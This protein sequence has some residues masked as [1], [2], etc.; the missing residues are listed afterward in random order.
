MVVGSGL[1]L[2]PILLPVSLSAQGPTTAAIQGTI[3]VDPQSEVALGRATVVLTNLPTGHRWL[4]STDDAGRYFIDGVPVGGP[5]AMDVEAAGFRPA[6]RSGLTLGLGQRYV[7]DFVLDPL[8]VLAD[9]IEVTL[10]RDPLSDVARTGPEHRVGLSTIAHL[11]VLNRDILSLALESP[12]AKSTVFGLSIAGHNSPYN[13]FQVD[14]GVN[15]NLYGR[16]SPVPGGLINLVSVPGGGGLRI[17]PID[18]VKEVQVL[19]SPFDVRQGS[20]VG[21]VINVVTESGTNILRGSGFVTLQ[22]DVLVGGESADFT[23]GQFGGTLGGAILPDRLHYFLAADLQAGSIPYGG[24]IIGPESIGGADSAG[25]GIR[26]ATATRFQSILRDTYGVDAGSFGPV[27]GQNPAQSLL[28]KLSWQS[29]TGNLLEISQTYVH[30][31]DQGLF[32]D[33][34]PYGNFDLTSADIRFGSTTSAT[35]VNWTAILGDR[36]SAE[37]IAA[38]LRIRDFCRGQEDS[39][40]FLSVFADNGI[41]NAG[42]KFSCGVGRGDLAQDALEFTGN[43]TIGL[44]GHRLTA[45]THDELLHFGDPVFPVAGRWFFD[46]VDSLAQGIPSFYSLAFPSP[47]R[48]DGAVADFRARQLGFYLQDQWS[49]VRD[50]ILTIGLRLDVPYFPDRPLANP[51]L[52]S[53]LGIDNSIVPSGNALWS[54]RLGFHY[55]V[56]GTTRTVIRGGIGLFTGR[57]AYAMIGDPYLSTGMDALF[58]DCFGD[59]VPEF[60]I[61]PEHQPEACRSGEPGTAPLVSYFDRDLRFPQDFKIAAGIDRRLP[62][63]LVA[64]ADFLYSRATQQSYFVDVNLLPPGDTAAGEGDRALYGDIDP[65]TGFAVPHRRSAAFGTVIQQTNRSGDESL[66]LSAQ[67]QGRIQDR[68]DMNASYAYSKS[69]DLITLPGG[70]FSFSGLG[71]SGDAIASTALDGTFADQRSRPSRYD[72]RHWIR[73]SGTIELPHRVFLSAI[74]QLAS[75]LPYTF[76]VEGDAN[77]DGFGEPRFGQQTNDIVYVPRDAG[78][79]E[80]VTLVVPGAEEGEWS[81]A[82]DSTYAR[83]EEFIR[84]S[85]CLR[86]QRGTIMRRNSCRNPWRTSLDIRVSKSVPIGWGRRAELTADLFNVPN[87][88]ARD[89]GLVTE[90]SPFFVEEIPMLRLVGYDVGRDRGTYT[91]A[92]PSLRNQSGNWR[93]QIGMHYEF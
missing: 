86:E 58:V 13:N 61:D 40:P 57:P 54:P 19:T 69:R 78:P 21:G 42:D 52:A 29:G 77:G 30:G 64:T 46:S 41:L 4:V 23:T 49:P 11:P 7:A 74:Y 66:F 60:T 35:R 44:G 16:F 84:S 72:L 93:M 88:L 43:L 55:D 38:W 87:F 39:F 3:T 10:A 48:P 6:S 50:L 45:G 81:P 63:G 79:G 18:A 17:V 14:G 62:G 75:G 27:N 80:D 9:A 92:L 65:T 22:N 36:A 15:S 76:I 1:A 24:P 34:D 33:R 2:L 73:A 70:M 51:V 37:V 5:Y 53:E 26:R 32:L 68:V 71:L 8:V 31:E 12:H 59:D 28:G 20:F 47:L 82:P 25:V 91:L 85:E 89:W 90:A 56:G 83:L 67:V